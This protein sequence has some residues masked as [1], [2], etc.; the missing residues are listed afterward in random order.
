MVTSKKAS[1]KA[2]LEGK[3]AKAH[4]TPAPA[5]AP[6][7]PAEANGARAYRGAVVSGYFDKKVQMTLRMLSISEETTVQKLLAEAINLLF[8]KRKMPQ[9]ADTTPSQAA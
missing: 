5:A 4:H 7:A 8:E 1:L 2:A 6:A 9:I 3:H